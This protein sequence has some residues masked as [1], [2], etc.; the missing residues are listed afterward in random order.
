MIGV[1]AWCFP[2]HL[3]PITYHLPVEARIGDSVRSADEKVFQRLK[4]LLIRG[5]H[6]L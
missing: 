3:R 5:D 6:G 1:G 4:Y 2:Y